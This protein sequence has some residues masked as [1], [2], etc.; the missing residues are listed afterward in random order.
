MKNIFQYMLL[1]L[2][3]VMTNCSA[4]AEESAANLASR[5]GVLPLE[6]QIHA[7]LPK[8]RE[9]EVINSFIEMGF[10]EVLMRVNHLPTID[11]IMQNYY[12]TEG[13]TF[14]VRAIADSCSPYLVEKLAPCLYKGDEME[15]RGRGELGPDYGESC[16][17][18]LLIGKLLMKSP[19]FSDEVKKWAN[20]WLRARG[21]YCISAAR[22]FWELNQVALKAQEFDKV[23][24]PVED[25]TPLPHVPTVAPPNPVTEP[26]LP[27]NPPT[28]PEVENSPPQ[29]A[30]ATKYWWIVGILLALIGSFFM[31]KKKA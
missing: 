6:E 4:T 20:S 16:T 18:A 15:I 23:T 17:T 26:I 7:N 9:N 22:Q 29:A 11:K 27:A 31:L 28:Q 14:C 3:W 5:F 24:V 25:L 2:S 10:V 13:K 12:E 19:E 30:T 21:P 8:G 1:G